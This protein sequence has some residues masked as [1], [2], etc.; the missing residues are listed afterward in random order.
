MN[1]TKEIRVFN[2]PDSAIVTVLVL[3]FRKISSFNHFF[4]GAMSLSA[5]DGETKIATVGDHVCVV[6]K[7][8]QDTLCVLFVELY[9]VFLNSND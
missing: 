1:A 3:V 5:C 6:E 2:E 8:A 4:A 7:P 9:V